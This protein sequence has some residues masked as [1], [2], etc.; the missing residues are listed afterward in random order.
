MKIFFILLLSVILRL[1]SLN[2][3]LWLDEAINVVYA[4]DNSLWWFVSQ[5]PIGDFHPPGYFFILWIWGY[6]FGFSE[7]S[8]RMPSVIFGVLTVFITYLIGKDLFSKKIGLLSALFLALAPLHIYYSQEARMYSFAAFAVT[9]STYWLVRLIYQGRNALWWY[10]LSVVL[11]F[12]SDYVAYFVLPVHIVYILLTQRKILAR[13][14]TSFCFSLISFIP[15]LFVLPDQLE[16][17]TKTASSLSEWG[18]VVGGANYKTAL[19]LPLKALLGRIT[20]EPANLYAVLAGITALPY[21]IT[22][23]GLRKKIGPFEKLII[24]WLTVP[25][26]LAFAVS[27]FIPVFSYFRLLFILPAFYLISAVGLRYISP[28]WGKSLIGII[29][30]FELAL[31]MVY[32]LDNNFHRENWREAV[33]F[34]QRQTGQQAVVLFKSNEVVAPYIYYSLKPGLAYPAY[35]NIPVNEPSDL[36]DLKQFFWDKRRVYV[37]DYLVEV[38][39]PKKILEK[40]LGEMGFKRSETYN[41][42]G[43]GFIDLY[44][45]Q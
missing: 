11:V 5:Y 41:F 17:G 7:V 12:S 32:L 33:D 44:L 24:C 21:V 45:L 42:Q 29:L 1:I 27:F 20:V 35:L 28:I 37:F 38:T 26:V 16:Q 30:S 25:P 40:K 39:D 19:L 3:S 43:V 2:Q 14:L 9:F 34:V 36:N 8:V 18:R 22:I 23:F 6:L 15:W 4:R 10:A 13:F 31:G